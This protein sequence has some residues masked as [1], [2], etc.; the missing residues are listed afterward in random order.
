MPLSFGNKTDYPNILRGI[1]M[2]S[3]PKRKHP[4]IIAAASGLLSM[5]MGVT[6][7]LAAP[8][9]I[10]GLSGFDVN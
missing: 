10:T 7:A 2:N 3:I 9:A 5:T 4:M 8:G 6:P 1:K